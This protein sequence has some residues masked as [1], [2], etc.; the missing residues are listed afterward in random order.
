L[1]WRND[2]RPANAP[3][4]R[5]WGAAKLTF[6]CYHT[7]LPGRLLEALM[8]GRGQGEMVRL[9]TPRFGR[10]TFI[11]TERAAEIIVNAVIPVAVAAGIVLPHPRLLQAACWMYR[12]SPSR[13]SN[14]IVRQIEG[15]YLAGR[16][17]RGA[18]WQQGAIE[19]HQRYLST[20]RRALS[21]V[22]E[23]MMSARSTFYG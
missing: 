3:E 8:A 2:T 16:E 23:S 12:L 21:M 7:R 15:R 17:L 10:E 20:D 9:L 19:F 11:G 13:G 22:A 5:L 4:R 14:R 6:D 1:Y 18:F